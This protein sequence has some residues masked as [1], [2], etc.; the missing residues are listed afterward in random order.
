MADPTFIVRVQLYFHWANGSFSP[1]KQ[2][3]GG[4]IYYLPRAHRT[5]KT[6]VRAF[7]DGLRV[8]TGNPFLRSYNQSS[9]MVRFKL[10]YEC[11]Q[12]STQNRAIQ[13]R[14]KLSAG[15]ALEQVG[16]LVSPFCPRTTVPMVS[17][18]KSGS[19][20]AGMAFEQM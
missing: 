10:L 5:D 20:A 14:L 3:G 4:L 9:L 6:G 8:L 18:A 7:P 19:Q 11:G 1:V 15:T 12:Y 13:R 16:R 2:V 17:E